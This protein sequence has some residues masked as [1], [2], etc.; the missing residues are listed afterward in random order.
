MI[1]RHVKLTTAGNE[2]QPAS[3]ASGNI[4]DFYNTIYVPKMQKYFLG[5]KSLKKSAELYLLNRNKGGRS[6]EKNDKTEK[7]SKASSNLTTDAVV[8]VQISPSNNVPL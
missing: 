6:E 1:V 8:G 3:K 7:V 4:V 2:I 5:S